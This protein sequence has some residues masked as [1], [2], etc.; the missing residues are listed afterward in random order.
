MYC[1]GICLEVLKKRFGMPIGLTGASF[2]TPS[3]D[4]LN[5]AQDTYRYEQRLVLISSEIHFNN[6]LQCVSIWLT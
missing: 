3:Q 4:L 5:M 6:I 2:Q 1:R